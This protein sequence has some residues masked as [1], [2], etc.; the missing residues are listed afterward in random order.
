MI[1]IEQIRAARAMVNWSQRQLAAAAGLSLRNIHN[2]EAGLVVP[3]LETIKA[4]KTALE[5]ANIEFGDDCT[6]TLRREVFDIEKREGEGALESL[7]R[8]FMEAYRQGTKELLLCN[9]IEKKWVEMVTSA[10]NE[11]YNKSLMRFGVKERCLI[12]HGDKTMF[13]Y[14]TFYRWMPKEYFREVSYAVYG[15]TLALIIWSPTVRIAIIRNTHIADSY[16]RHFEFIWERSEIPPVAELAQRH[17]R[18]DEPEI[19]Q[20]ENGAR[21]SD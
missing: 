8:D 6:V 10:M 14:P 7:V 4:I 18:R 17:P 5:K 16:R 2:I 3:R 20:I 1:A 12:A 21:V 15:T 13:G 11:E 19:W 9:T